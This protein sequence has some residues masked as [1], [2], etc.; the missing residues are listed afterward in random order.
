MNQTIE[1]IL[2]KVEQNEV[3][4]TTTQYLGIKSKKPLT[5]IEKYTLN[6]QSVN[7]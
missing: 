5:E 2:N 4:T 3:A 6:E 1:L 7:R